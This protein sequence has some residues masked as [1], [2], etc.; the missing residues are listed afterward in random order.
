MR[1]TITTYTIT[2]IKH[3]YS[4]QYRLLEHS[5]VPLQTHAA[6]RH[7]YHN[8]TDFYMHAIP[9]KLRCRNSMQ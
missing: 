5:N 3:M 6:Y 8:I 1:A 2:P 9:H 4:F 7:I